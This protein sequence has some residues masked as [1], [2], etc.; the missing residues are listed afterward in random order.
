MGEPRYCIKA[1]RK[2]DPHIRDAL[3]ELVNS[4]EIDPK[5]N[6]EADSLAKHDL[7]NYEFLLGIIIWYDILVAVNVV[8]KNFFKKKKKDTSID[9]T[10]DQLKGLINFFE[11]Y[12]IEGYKSTKTSSKELAHEMEIE[13]VF[14]KNEY[15]VETKNLMK[16]RIVNFANHLKRLLELV[17]L[18]F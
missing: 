9:K 13:P 17:I 16:M 8:S 10:I 2:Q 18:Y 15:S 4:Y 5:T 11:K 12:R 3:Y 7:E 14:P 6:S 1:I